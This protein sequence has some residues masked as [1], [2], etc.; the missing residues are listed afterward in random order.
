MSTTIDVPTSEIGKIRVFSLSM[1]DAEAR[2]LQKDSAAMQAMVGAQVDP[3][4]VDIFPVSNLEG[5]GLAG[6]LREGNGVP[7]EQLA[8]DRVKLD[9]LD[10]LGG[11]VLILYS[12]AFRNTAT[13]FTPAPALTI[14]GTYDEARTDWSATETVKAEAAKP[15]TAPPET[16][17]KRPSD[18]AMSGRIATVAL[19]VMFAL[20][21]LVIWIAG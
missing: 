20:T 9:K 14:I 18:A 7:T 10:T 17:K 11:W 4:Y 13:T 6:F 16:V 12:S 15:F 19:I 2:E 21:G 3:E 8:P 1:T 5:V